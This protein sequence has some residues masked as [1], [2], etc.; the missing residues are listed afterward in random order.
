MA[1]TEEMHDDRSPASSVSGNAMAWTGSEEAGQYTVK[2]VGRYDGEQAAAMSCPCQLSA[3]ASGTQA[4][5]N[6]LVD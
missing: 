6:A 3:E 4:T 2:R 5:A 1:L